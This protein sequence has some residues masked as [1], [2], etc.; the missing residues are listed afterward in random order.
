MF[1]SA[2][3]ATFLVKY[4]PNLIG[5]F[6]RTISMHKTKKARQSTI[7]LTHMLPAQK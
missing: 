5:I 4:Q 3:C 1:L 7:C 2:L 6:Q